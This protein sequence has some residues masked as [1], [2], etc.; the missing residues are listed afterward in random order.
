MCLYLTLDLEKWHHL[1]NY[2][3]LIRA[4]TT[5]LGEVVCDS[6]KH[7]LIRFGYQNLLP[8]GVYSCVSMLFLFQLSVT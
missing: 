8:L 4:E 6:T 7:L 5:L 3:F 2:Y 1:R